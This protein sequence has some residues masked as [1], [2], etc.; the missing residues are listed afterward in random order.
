MGLDTSHDCWHGGYT[1]FTHWRNWLAGMAGYKITPADYE[2]GNVSPSPDID[3]GSFKPENY[4]G[5]W[6]ETPKD[7]LLILLVHSDCD[8][9]IKAKHCELLAVRLA[10][11]LENLI[12][13]E[14]VF[15]QRTEQ[16]IAGLRDA[17]ALGE[18]VEFR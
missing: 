1:G 6:A 14:D 7:P 8:G 2:A 4:A 12:I 16:F 13:E 11:L 18:S 15:R 10:G 17:A 3:W 5:E 9:E